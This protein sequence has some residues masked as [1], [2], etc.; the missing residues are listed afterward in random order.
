[1]V[2]FDDCW[3]RIVENEG[4]QFHTKRNLPFKYKIKSA[5]V[6][7]SRT[8]YSIS[9]KDFE[10]VFKLGRVK[11][12]G[13]ISNEVRGPAYVWAIMHDERIRQF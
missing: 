7:P 4:E 1:M 11:G 3:N 10:T 6:I 8:D 13:I 9:K 12:P 2:Y 5:T